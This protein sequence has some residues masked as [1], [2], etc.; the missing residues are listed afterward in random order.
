MKRESGLGSDR[1]EVVVEFIG[2]VGR[3]KLPKQIC[4][5]ISFETKWYRAQRERAIAYS[6]AS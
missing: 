1:D 5:R 6:F 3:T 4:L 2:N